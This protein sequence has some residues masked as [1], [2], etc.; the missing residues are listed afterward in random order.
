MLIDNLHK[1]IEIDQ[2]ILVK[3]EQIERD[4]SNTGLI[5]EI[6]ADLMRQVAFIR[7]AQRGQRDMEIFAIKSIR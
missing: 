6:E 1:A 5:A 7:K 3:L 2:C 4:P